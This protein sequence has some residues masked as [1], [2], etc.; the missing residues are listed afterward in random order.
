MNEGWESLKDEFSKNLMF[1][2]QTKILN[3]KIN[4]ITISKDGGNVGHSSQ[5]S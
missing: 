1:R 2:Y 3:E 4:S 5:G